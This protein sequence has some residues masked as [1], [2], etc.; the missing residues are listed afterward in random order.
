[1]IDINTSI[2][3][4]EKQPD[5][6]IFPN[7]ATGHITVHGLKLNDEIKVF[8]IAAN[9]VM[10]VTA[11]HTQEKISLSGITPGMYLIEVE[12]ARRAKFVKN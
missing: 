3:E 5:V 9:L 1:V 8:G 2:S 4:Y 6:L 7:P 11:S 10:Q 12:G